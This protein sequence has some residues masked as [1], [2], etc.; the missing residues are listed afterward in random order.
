MRSLRERIAHDG[1]VFNFYC[2]IPAPFIAELAGRAGF[3]AVTLDLQ[4]GLIDY[5][6]AVAMIT[7][8]SGCDVVPMVRTPPLDAGLS[9]KLLDAGF[10]GITCALIETGDEAEALVTACRYPPRGARSFG[11]LRAGTVYQDYFAR[12]SEMVT[13][14]AMVESRK[15]YENLDEILGV[16]GIDGI[17]IGPIDLALS[18]GYLP[19]LDNMPDEVSEA[20]EHILARCRE[21][22]KICGM[23]APDGIQAAALVRRG[24]SFVT[25]SNDVRA[26]GEALGA[27]IRDARDPL[28]E[29]G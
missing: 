14:F 9:M 19:R 11:P 2:T 24:F 28:G 29:A 1:H 7:A 22:G 23:I 25:I 21:T 3:G 26:I 6:A 15:G 5:H 20:I 27:W 10:L 17:Y 13:L 16:D 12:S 18:M 8:L 4:H